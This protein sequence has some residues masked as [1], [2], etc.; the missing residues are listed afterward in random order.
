V[1]QEQGSP[2]S[3]PH[4]IQHE[5]TKEEGRS[6]GVVEE[7]GME[8]APPPP[9]RAIVLARP[10]RNATNGVVL[11]GRD[12]FPEFG[13]SYTAA[14]ISTASALAVV[15]KARAVN[16]FPSWEFEG[17]A[18]VYDFNPT[19]KPLKE[20]KAG[21][22]FNLQLGG[23]REEL[24]YDIPL[25]GLQDPDSRT[26]EEP[27][28]VDTFFVLL[29]AVERPLTIE[30]QLTPRIDDQTDPE[31]EYAALVKMFEEQG[32]PQLKRVREL[33]DKAAQKRLLGPFS[34]RTLTVPFFDDAKTPDLRFAS[35]V[36][37]VE[38]TR[39]RTHEGASLFSHDQNL[40]FRAISGG[41]KTSTILD[42]ACI[43][44]TIYVA[45]NAKT[46][47]NEQRL[48]ES[49]TND[50]VFPE[51]LEAIK[52]NCE[53]HYRKDKLPEF[54]EEGKR[55]IMADICARLSFLLWLVQSNQDITPEQILLAQ[56]SGGRDIMVKAFKTLRAAHHQTLYALATYC[57]DNLERTIKQQYGDDVQL[58]LAIDEAQVAAKYCNNDTGF[59]FEHHEKHIQRS[60]LYEYVEL[61][62]QYA[63]AI[64]IAGTGLSSNAAGDI[65]SSVGK[66]IFG[67]VRLPFVDAEGVKAR[68]G[69][70]INVSGIDWSQVCNLEKITGRCRWVAATILALMQVIRSSSSNQQKRSG[71]KTT[72]LV[73]AIDKVEADWTRHL[74]ES[75]YGKLNR[76]H[77]LP[78]DSTEGRLCKQLHAITWL[79]KDHAHGMRIQ[80]NAQDTGDMLALGLVMLVKASPE[81]A[82]QGA[83]ERSSRL[84][85]ETKVD[86]QGRVVRPASGAPTLTIGRDPNESIVM[87]DKIG[88]GAL[89]ELARRAHW[90]PSD[91]I[92]TKIGNATDANA[93]EFG[94]RFET[95]V[96]AAIVH[97]TGTVADLI[98]AV[99]PKK[100]ASMSRAGR[101]T[102]SPVPPWTEAATFNC[103][104]CVCDSHLEVCDA[105]RATLNGQSEQDLLIKPDNAARGDFLLPSRREQRF[106]F[107]VFASAKCLTEPLSGESRENDFNS[108]KPEKQYTGK[109][110]SNNS[111]SAVARAAYE[112]IL[113]EMQAQTEG[114][115]LRLHVVLPG[116]AKDR[117]G[118]GEY[119][120]RVLIKD[121][122]VRII[123]DLQ[124]YE[125]LFQTDEMRRLVQRIIAMKRYNV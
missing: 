36:P 58:N 2:P 116:Y 67:P 43:K 19:D 102:G 42:A 31:T 6:G 94:Y 78:G 69:M 34:P 56:L 54:Q 66:D 90:D 109:L 117:D 71:F 72:A 87:M 24:D 60:I 114:R 108:T 23:D 111:T 21:R 10:T 107:D 86:D 97:F 38:D 110:G 45:C 14:E 100:Y 47:A 26:A 5:D 40:L 99:D 98:R 118:T 30:R 92:A 46:E 124:S 84:A 37:G 122:E 106:P 11:L 85:D 88:R 81:E 125:A 53:K 75:L 8:A 79:F 55:L 41:G 93:I 123:I 91:Y 95:L 52:Q 68:L 39:Y 49:V 18:M 70:M 44:P 50:K 115:V 29:T 80:C 77:G 22:P 104:Y 28:I 105:L 9:I 27:E 73:N 7:K 65:S 16:A 103:A 48:A 25:H 61:W 120:D 13:D 57:S 1:Q 32:M 82:K 119:P 96:A 35:M 83:N 3:S 51:L 33:F 59:H 64:V 17:K 15:A 4:R 62:R 12:V 112:P 76:A 89:E 101:P 63:P 20:L 121:N 113:Q 74:A